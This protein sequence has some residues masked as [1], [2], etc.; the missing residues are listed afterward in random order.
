MKKMKKGF[1]IIELV[2]V[3]AV[4]G[5]LSAVLIPTFSGVTEKGKK[6]AAIENAKNAYT[7]ALVDEDE[8]N[9][10]TDAIYYDAV[11]GYY[12]VIK[13]GQLVNE[14]FKTEAEA[15]TEAG[16]SVETSTESGFLAKT[17]AQQ[18]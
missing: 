9:N 14:A 5:I 3:I 7:Q 1:T 8:S 15:E 12:V 6:A 18:G 11:N 2:I 10:Y 17:P 4:I 16:I 13:D